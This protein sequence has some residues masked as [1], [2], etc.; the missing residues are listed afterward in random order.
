MLCVRERLADTGRKAQS[1]ERIEDQT[2]TDKGSSVVKE[3]MNV[4]EALTIVRAILQALVLFGIGFLFGV[5][6]QERR[7]KNA[8]KQGADGADLGIGKVP[9]TIP[10]GIGDRVIGVVIDEGNFYYECLI[11][12]H[13]V[14]EERWPDGELCNVILKER[15]RT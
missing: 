1:I 9:L 4:G 10:Y 12:K 14:S 2:D 15:G 13:Y 8:E 5:R 6:L 3:E 7:D 11:L